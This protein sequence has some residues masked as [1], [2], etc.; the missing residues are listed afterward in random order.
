MPTRI[1]V[2]VTD[3]PVFARIYAPSVTASHTSFELVPP[4]PDEMAQRVTAVLSRYPWLVDEVDGVVAGYAYAAEHRTR[5]AYQWSVDVS[6]YV[7]PAFQRRGAARRLYEALF[8]VLRR[9][10]FVN[11]YAGIALP[12]AASVHLHEAAG[13]ESV[14]V[15]RGEGF[16]LGNWVDVGWWHLRLQPPPPDPAPPIPFPDLDGAQYGA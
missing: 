16:K 13:F 4:S 3:A 12:N 15:C 7:D 2:A 6:V 9:Q 8:A 14:G 10:G 11:A 1:A 5:A